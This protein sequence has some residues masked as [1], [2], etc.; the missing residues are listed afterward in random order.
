MF[1]I[2]ASFTNICYTTFLN[3]NLPFKF[4]NVKFFPALI[5][6]LSII[7]NVIVDTAT[8]TRETIGRNKAYSLKVK[9]D[10]SVGD[11]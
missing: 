6:G 2:N 9:F 10:I 3:K 1:S 5:A 11:Q 8:T 4:L 7:K